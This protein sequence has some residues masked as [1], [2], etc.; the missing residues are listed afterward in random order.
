MIKHNTSTRFNINLNQ[1][2]LKFNT[3]KRLASDCLR[4]KWIEDQ[5]RNLK[6]VLSPCAYCFDYKIRNILCDLCLIDKDICNNDGNSGLIGYILSK[7]GNSLL[8][9]ISSEDYNLVRISLEELKITGIISKQL[10]TKIR[11]KFTSL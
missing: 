3:I 6:R 10:K 1:E 4:F 11:K 7:Y 2:K 8:K 5:K 9:D